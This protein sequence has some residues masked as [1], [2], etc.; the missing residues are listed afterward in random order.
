M[1]EVLDLIMLK[2]K[3]WWREQLLSIKRNLQANRWRIAIL[4]VLL[5]G[6][7]QH[8]FNFQLD[9]FS[10]KNSPKT[11]H[12]VEEMDMSGVIADIVGSIGAKEDKKQVPK[13]VFT[14]KST[15]NKPET[16]ASD[17]GNSYSNVGFWSGKR[18][19]KKGIRERQL[20][21]IQ[22]FSK[23]AQTEMDK[24]GIPASIILA[25]G[26]IES[27]A[28]DSRLARNNNNHF[29]VK[30]FSKNCQKGHCSNFTDDS[31][32]DFFRVYRSPWESY[33]AHSIMIKTKHYHRLLRYGTRNYN[34][35]AYGLKKLGYATDPHYAQSLIRTIESLN[36]QQFDR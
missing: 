19:E 1:K 9:G 23:I 35:W 12:Q 17:V 11:N 27:N 3:L 21:Y 14:S 24:F 13:A 7:S 33:R 2:L 30:C 34:A 31:H 32:K 28:G 29:G 4:A 6:V 16:T 26:I 20:D 36:L 25:Q 15:R 10:I 5:Y 8:N 18:N 22:R